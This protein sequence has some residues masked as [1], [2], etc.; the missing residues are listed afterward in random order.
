MLSQH[1]SASVQSCPCQL[2]MSACEK[3]NNIHLSGAGHVLSWSAK[4]Q[5]QP[6]T[7][8]PTEA[9][10][11]RQQPL[12]GRKLRVSQ[13]QPAHLNGSVRQHIYE[14]A[15]YFLA[16]LGRTQSESSLAKCVVVV[17]A[18]FL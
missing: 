18:D 15:M 7:D 12:A 3:V 4:K 2:E 11:V 16:M 9:S 6:G 17:G 1:S 13:K 10:A 14:M 5:L 8:L